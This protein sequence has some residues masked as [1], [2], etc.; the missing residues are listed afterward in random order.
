[1]EF[2]LTY[3]GPLKSNGDSDHKQ[4]IRNYFKPQLE[5][6]WEIPP[7]DS[8]KEYLKIESLKEVKNCIL[9]RSGFYFAPL[10]NQK[11]K[12]L[13]QLDVLLLW[14]EEPGQILGH[15]GDIDN[16]LKTLFDALSIPTHDQIKQIQTKL[17]DDKEK[18]FYCLLED[19][20]LITSVNV[21]THT[22]LYPQEQDSFIYSLINVKIKAK[23][24]IWANIN[25]ST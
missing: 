3:Q 10:V 25:I 13:C 11:L 2:Y 12:L 22:L 15:G 9:E 17:S 18:P 23:E 21:K 14:Q 1:M 20:K 4:E 8:H 19:D 6:L 16:R 5:K 7:L 24:L